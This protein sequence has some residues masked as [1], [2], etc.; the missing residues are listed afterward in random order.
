MSTLAITHPTLKDVSTRMDP[1]GKID[2][3]VEM[4]RQSNEILDDAVF[5]EGNLPTGHKYTVRTGLPEQVT[6][7]CGMLED[8]AEVDKAL[9]DLNGNTSA[10]R[11]SEDRA[12]IQGFNH[13]VA[14]SFFYES[15]LTTPE[16][17]TGLAPRFNSLSA[18]NADNI[19]NA[20]GSGNCASIWLVGWGPEGA[21]GIYPK[22]SVAGLSH[23]DKGQ[24]TKE[25]IDGAGGMA[26]MYRSHYRWDLGFGVKD[27]RNV[28]RI[29]NISVSDLG[30]LAN[31]KLLIQW[32]IE[33]SEK[34]ESF[35]SC[36]F[37]WY[38]NKT[39]RTKLRLGILEK[40]ASNLSW[41]SV[42]GKRVMVFD[43]IPVRRC[44]SLL[45][46]ETAVA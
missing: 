3:I 35:G 26:E 33:A 6:D 46:T 18:E 19:V 17:I 34:I 41:E 45:L 42:A 10:F 44:D 36:R 23:T 21:F 7:N 11:L 24:V 31:T 28:V 29:A 25:N 39:I 20:A 43:D 14:R 8:Y 4:L 2:D 16:A 13:K 38:V 1:K 5:L 37:A 30:T 40:V 22:G 15:E 12:H 27:W 32:M 9:A